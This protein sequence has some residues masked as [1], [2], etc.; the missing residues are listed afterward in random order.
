M[1]VGTRVWVKSQWRRSRGLA[2]PGEYTQ[3][4]QWTVKRV[5][6]DGTVDVVQGSSERINRLEPMS[7]TSCKRVVEDWISEHYREMAGN[8]WIFTP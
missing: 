8:G 4:P 6:S 5:H 1:K 2:C 7:M 3:R